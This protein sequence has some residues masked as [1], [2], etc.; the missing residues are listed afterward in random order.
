MCSS[1]LLGQL[2]HRSPFEMSQWAKAA[3]GLAGVH[4][5]LGQAE[6]AFPL[7]DQAW[8]TLSQLVAHDSGAY[9]NEYLSTSLIA[10]V[11][12][13]KSGKR[14]KASALR[15]EATLHLLQ[16]AKKHGGGFVI[17][18]IWHLDQLAL[19][20]LDEEDLD[21]ALRWIT[22]AVRW[23]RK[24][25]RD[26]DKS[27]FEVIAFTFLSEVPIRLA[28]LEGKAALVAAR[29]ALKAAKIGRAHV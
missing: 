26:H 13:A 12:A 24:L 27:V 29:N 19:A 3:I 21:S 14:R 17:E 1:D 8:R 7:A 18:L 11:A 25:P 2:E 22:E 16:L 15:D 23:V 10:A 20:N 5:Q 4:L 9:L 6:L 28:R